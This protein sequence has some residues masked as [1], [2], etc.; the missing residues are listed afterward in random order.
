MIDKRSIA[1]DG[2]RVKSIGKKL[3]AIAVAGYIAMSPITPI[4]SGGG[5]TSKTDIY[6]KKKEVD[7]KFLKLTITIDHV[8]Y[9]A[10]K[11]PK[12]DIKVAARNIT[13]G[14]DNYNRPRV[15]VYV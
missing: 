3:F 4:T 1:T 5:I 11:E 8:K 10:E 7:K 12:E 15:S 6:N 14:D 2:Y 9:S 13:T